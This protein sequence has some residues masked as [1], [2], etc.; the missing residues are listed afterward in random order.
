MP[1]LESIR[2]TGRSAA[3]LARSVRD[4]E[5]PSSNLGAP[6]GS[7]TRV[8]VARSLERVPIR[9]KLLYVETWWGQGKFFVT[10]NP[11]IKT[12]ADIKG[13][14]VLLGLR[15]FHWRSALMGGVPRDPRNDGDHQRAIKDGDRRKPPPVRRGIPR[16]QTVLHDFLP[17]RAP[18]E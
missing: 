5:V 17:A 7:S 10:F 1:L 4:A 15:R 2:S 13:K 12:I 3:W 8:L 9:F 6:T 18:C 14:R 16:G 11:S